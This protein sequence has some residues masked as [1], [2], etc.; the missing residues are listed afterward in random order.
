MPKQR[1]SPIE[2][3]LIQL[4]LMIELPPHEAGWPHETIEYKLK[5]YR[6]LCSSGKISDGG[7]LLSTL[8][9]GRDIRAEM[10]AKDTQ[11]AVLTLK[12]CHPDLFII[13]NMAFMTKPGDILSGR[14]GARKMDVSEATW[15]NMYKRGLDCVDIALAAVA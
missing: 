6:Q 12:R 5:T 7:L 9:H 2:N 15:R 10:R 1:L 4:A 3:R 8:K 11:R 13:I 14:V